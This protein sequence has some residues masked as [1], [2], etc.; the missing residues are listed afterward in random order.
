MS[1]IKRVVT[2]S[3]AINQS[4]GVVTTRN[5]AGMKVDGEGPTLVR[6]YRKE[7]DLSQPELAV[8]M[9]EAEREDGT[10]SKPS[11]SYV[12]SVE[13]RRLKPSRQRALLMDAILCADGEIVRAFG[14]RADGD[15][16]PPH[17]ARDER[18]AALELAVSELRDLILEQGQEIV[19][20]QRLAAQE[21]GRQVARPDS[22]AQPEPAAA[23]VSRRTRRAGRSSS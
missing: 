6:R 16:H 22:T 15:T 13:N 14:Y 18:I 4:I 7:R 21:F 9:W 10:P 20:V 1:S 5:V 17:D 11:S 2:T 19:K 23:Q 8:A 12:S 3:L